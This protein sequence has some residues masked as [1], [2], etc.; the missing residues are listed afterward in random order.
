M[1]LPRPNKNDDK[2]KFISRCM[3]NPTMNKEFPSSD[4]RYKV[5]KSQWNK[6]F[7]ELPMTLTD[8]WIEIFR[9]GKYPQGNFTEADVKDIAEKYNPKYHEAAILKNHEDKES[10]G[11]VKELKAKGDTLL[12]KFKQISK[13]FLEEVKAGKWKKRSAE[14]YP[15]LDGKGKYLRAVSFVA[16]P[17]VKDLRPHEFSDDKG[18]YFAYE[19]NETDNHQPAEGG[20]DD[21]GLTKE[22][23]QALIDNKTN[24]L[25]TSFE[26]KLKAKDDEHEKKISEFS[27][28]VK[29]LKEENK[30]TLTKLTEAQAAQLETDARQFTEELKR[31]GKLTP[32]MEKNAKMIYV[33]LAKVPGT[34]KFKEKMKEGDK[35]VE[36]EVEKTLLEMFKEQCEA[37]PQIVKLGESEKLEGETESTSIDISEYKGE[38]IDEDSVKLAERTEVLMKKDDKLSY[39]DA[40]IFAE[41]ELR[42]E[43]VI[44]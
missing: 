7:K 24:D 28:E 23:V 40:M 10:F 13:D 6:K 14:I 21:M 19:F 12:A 33:G 9:A 27:E 1:P 17:Q 2:D 37:T 44:K 29:S 42:R 32:A 5:C 18:K 15:D 26:E 35:E 41:K 20:Q 34:V 8:D 36:K 30:K 31:K 39:A 38:N 3:G 25:T 4:Q 16:I 22:E 43:G 11:W